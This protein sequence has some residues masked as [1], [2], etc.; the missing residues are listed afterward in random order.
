VTWKH[1]AGLFAA[2]ALPV[3][4]KFSMACTDVAFDKLIGLSMAVA[5]GVLGNAGMTAGKK[6]PPAA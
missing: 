2:L 4:C 6:D 1:I 5:V 3:V